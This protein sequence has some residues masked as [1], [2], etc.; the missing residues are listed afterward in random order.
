MLRRAGHDV[1]VVANGVEAVDAARQESFDIVLMDVQMPVLDGTEATRQI[2]AL[3]GLRGQVP[4]LAL[5]ADAMTGA[6]E[7]YLDTGMND[8]L[9]KPFTPESLFAK[10]AALTQGIPTV[11]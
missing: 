1:R 11:A 6:R 10:L 7:H 8:Y 2:R 4:V 5:T 9:A 3:G